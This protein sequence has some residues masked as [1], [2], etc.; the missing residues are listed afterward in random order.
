MTPARF[1]TIEEIYRAALDQEPDQ[2]SAFLDQSCKGDE[3]LRRKLEALLDSRERAAGFIENSAVGLATR[4]LE[5]QQPGSLVG[6]TI[7]HYKISEPIGTGGMG[8]VY[9][10]TDVV[11]GR[12]AALK[13]L[14]VQFTHDPDRLNRFQQEAHAVVAL[15]HPNI[16]TVYEIGE[17]QSIHYIASEL[18]EGETL[19]QRL[20]REPMQL[21]EALD[22]TIQVA[23]ALAAAHHAGIVHRDIKP[24]NVMLRPDGYVKV[25]DFGI[26]KLAEQEL[27]TSLPKD[28]ALLLVQTN[29]GSILGT[30]RYMSPEQARGAQVDKRTDI[31]SLGVVLYEMVTGH[32]PFNGETAREVMSSIL[33]TEPPPLTSY[34]KQTPAE[35][36][37]MISKTLR[38]DRDE[39]YGNARELLEALKNLRRKLEFKGMPPEVKQEI[40]LEIAHV[41][42]TDIVGYSKLPVDEQRAL[43]ERLNKIVRG[44]DEFKAADGAGR[45]IKIPTGDGIALVFYSRPEAPLECAVQISRSL[46]EHPQ[47]Q[48]RM[49]IHSG[50][51]SGVIDVNE[52]ANVAGSGM[53]VAQRVMDCGDAR[54][55]L[56]SKHAAEDLEQYGRWRPYLHALGKVEVKHGIELSIFNFYTD[57]VGNPQLPEKIRRARARRKAAVLL[58]GGVSLGVLL[59]GGLLIWGYQ[60]GHKTINATRPAILEKSIAV[61]PLQNLS[62][63]KENAFFADGV[64][65]ELLSNL[66][67]IKDLKVI[68]RT[69][70]MQ[71]KSGTKRNLKEIAQQLGVNNVVEGSVRRSGDHVRVSMQLIDARSDRHVWAENYDRKVADSVSLQ[72]ELATEIAS[73]VGA[74]L[75]PQEKARVAAKP[76]NNPAAYDAYLRARAIPIDWGW[77]LK[78]DIETAIHLYEQAVKLDP[79]FALAWAY[80]SIAQ[81]QSVFKDIES[82]PVQSPRAKDSL[83][84]AL[85][86]DPNLPEV[87]LA[88]GYNEEDDTR[89]LAEFRQAEQGLPNSADV[90]EA[91]AREQR[92]LGHWDG[93]VAELRRAI[94][95]DPRNISASNN[96]A[97]TCCAMRRFP[98]ALATLDR[99]LAWDPTNARALLTKVDALMAIGDLHAV[100]PLLVNPEL[101]A[102]R[103]AAYAGLQHNYA[104]AIEI[105]S[106]DLPVDSQRRDTNDILALAFNQQLAGDIAAAR[107]IYQKSVQDLRRQLEKVE[108]NSFVEADTRLSLGTVYAALGEAA[109]AIAEGQKA[110]A[111]V[112]SS[113]N[114]EFGPVMEDGVSRIYAQLGDADHAIPMVK[115]LLRTSYP[116]ATFL[117]PATLRLDPIWDKIRSDPR[118]QELT[119]EE[120]PLSEKSIAV[121]P[122]ENLSKD[123]ENAFFAGGVQ[124][125]ILTDLAKIA[126]LKVISRT[127][128]MKYKSDLERNLREIANTLGVSH[129]VEGSVQRAG[130]RVRVSAQLIDARNDTHLW[131]DHYDRDAADVFAIQTEIAQQIADQLKANLSP[132]EKAAIAERPTTDRV[133]YAYYTKA[134]EMDMLT[135]WEGEEKNL[136][137]KV[138]LLEKATQRDPNFALA[139]CELAKTHFDNFEVTEADEHLELAKNA[140][141]TAVRMRPDLGEA[142][143]ELARY[144]FET[145]A[146]TGS[147]DYDRAREELKVVRR[148]L[149]NNAEAL[150]IEAMIG[151]HE[152]QWEASLA[153]LK[154]ASELDPRNAEV[155]SRLV[156]LYVGMRRY[157]ELE[158]F[159]TG[160][161]ASSMLGISFDPSVR[162]TMKVAQGDPVGA[163][164]F[165]DQ[166]PLE[167]GP[168]AWIWGTRF[169]AALYLRDYD[170]ANRVIAATPAKW[171]DFAFDGISSDWAYGQVARARGDK[172]KALAAFTAARQKQGA[173]RRDGAIAMLDAGL[174]RKEQAIR[175]AQRAVE[176]VPISKDAVNGP[177]NVAALA[178]VYA[179][180]GERDRALEQLEKIATI[181]STADSVLTYGDLLLNPC[182]DDLR[183]DPRFDKIV[184]AAKAAS[185]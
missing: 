154:K 27:P 5:N 59:S 120:V 183:G 101:P 39:R 86:L 7:G 137:Q 176:L 70:A 177:L 147:N 106:K 21:S 81:R 60:S 126:D 129:V 158:Q 94:E 62:E 140:A 69:S 93:A 107:A 182:W 28:E 112:P 67:K 160:A 89:A 155:A 77:A 144:Y 12:K 136:N 4:I 16:L 95:L 122:F 57:E 47:L 30:V 116:G 125:E 75:T 109:P 3:V 83:N 121:L 152:N 84:H 179:W 34:V 159:L 133:A 24:E 115:R 36:Q 171:A 9:L 33:E 161:G 113:K 156:G 11:A 169:K 165:L 151:R 128:V 17:D 98:E 132:A 2:I 130:E 135:N 78:G 32:E 134:K 145:G 172:Q 43:I 74:T 131:A 37:E 25:L 143:L 52:R 80:L 63:D 91:I 104:A 82:E 185:R 173:L 64:Q 38:K 97:L 149:P 102:N 139:Y 8:E 61:L 29:L 170:R 73:A 53:N 105:L 181:P 87:H 1:E 127:S 46:K 85:A 19:R 10:A 184:A 124:D 103:R 72:G 22:V 44:T 163:Q 18:I 180:T 90:I 178:L 150:F 51:V 55:I 164:S 79:N 96:L 88:R 138:E 15:N 40:E 13:L 111:L 71:Y 66:S 108:P 148:K 42:L 174:G 110:M 153:N 118:F 175:E 58:V 141:E 166:V 146:V 45:L 14:P 41:L 123:E 100:E 35:L 92:A 48:L 114:P 167:Y 54:H 68:S 162:A 50:P 56:I 142:H 117:T 99:V 157:S 168:G 31:W 49:G 26:A 119:V 20:T 76:T 6:Q 65:D 23:N